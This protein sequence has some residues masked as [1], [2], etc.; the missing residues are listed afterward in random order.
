MVMLLEL[1]IRKN[2]M[3]KARMLHK[4]ISLSL[5]VNDLTLPAR[6]LFTWLIAVADDEGRLKGNPKYVKATVVPLTNWSPKLIQSYLKM[7]NDGGL[8][9]YWQENNEWFIEFVKWNDYQH[10]RKDRFEPSKL[11]SF[12]GAKDNQSTT[13]WQPDDNQTTPQANTSEDSVIK[14]NKSEDSN[15]ADK[16]SIK[17][18]REI[19]TLR[20][21]NPA[22]DYLPS[23]EKQTA[24]WD[25]WKNLEPNN[26]LGF[27]T[28]F[29]P[30]L[31]K[32]INAQKLYQLYREVKD[33][34]TI[35]N[36]AAVFFKKVKD[37]LSDKPSTNS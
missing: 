7:M 32:P 33:D 1:S 11:P 21:P 4:K 31:N 19:L 17:S 8:I 23:N 16:K 25:I 24:L 3:A 29:L 36:K 28:T 14:V 34:T 27:H 15:I 30:L 37:Y 5:Q 12:N 10:I 13:K 2:N 18:I 6:L 20:Y 26:P 9:H 35:K 22:T